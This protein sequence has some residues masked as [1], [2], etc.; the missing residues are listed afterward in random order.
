MRQ[1]YA[2]RMSI[3]REAAQKQM[4]GLI[5]VEEATAGMRTIGWIRTHAADSAVARRA[6]ALGLELTALSKF[7]LRHSHPPALILGFA[8]C[9]PSELR[10]GVGLPL[11]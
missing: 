8:G 7:T 9:N 5:D 3:L 6:R 10:R 11:C 2:E 1:A 4:S